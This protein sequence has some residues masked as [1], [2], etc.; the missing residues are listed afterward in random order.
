MAHLIL[1]IQILLIVCLISCFGFGQTDS[2]SIMLNE[3]DVMERKTGFKAK[4]LYDNQLVEELNVRGFT[5]L[6]IFENELNGDFWTSGDSKCVSGNLLDENDGSFL[7]L[8]WNKDIDG[9]DWVGFG[10][11]WDGW[12]GKDMGYVFDTLA[13]E[14]EVRSTGS[15]FTNLPWAFCFEDY[16]GEQAWLGYNQV[17]LMSETISKDWTKVQIPLSLF[18]F[19]ENDVNTAN[20]KQLL[21]QVFAEGLVEIKHIK[22]VPFSKKLKQEVKA[23]KQS[24]NISLDGK[25]DDWQHDFTTFG[26]GHEFAVSYTSDTVFFA[27][28]I[29]DD[30]PLENTQTKGD[31]WNGD[32]IEIAFSTNTFANK[33]RKFLLLSDRHIGLNCGS[34]SYIWDWKEEMTVENIAY[35]ITTSENGY[36]VEMAVPVTQL[37][38]MK[39]ESGMQL[40]LEIAIDLNVGDLRKKQERWNSGFSD[41]FHTSP[42]KW[43]VLTF[44]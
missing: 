9:C 30:S 41:G 21:I 19:E 26:N 6:T 13:L 42:Q 2:T 7:N 36:V 23:N 25:L 15:P 18:P 22:L 31:L 17:F 40:D 20:I 5:Q 38:Q 4:G 14:L 8:K 34:D 33:K 24:N 3:V 44:E 28:K 29:E 43:G 27:F 16:A 11:G 39:I 10:F 37:Y 35:K 1:K 32:A 12:M